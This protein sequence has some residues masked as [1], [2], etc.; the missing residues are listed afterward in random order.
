MTHIFKRIVVLINDVVEMESLLKKGVEFSK[1]HKTSLEVLFIHENHLFELPDY[2]LSP[3]AI[4]EKEINKE[5]IK[6]KIKSIIYSLEDKK[7]TPIFIVEEDSLDRVLYHGKDNK[8]ILFITS[9]HKELTQKL[10]EKTPYS[11]WILRSETTTYNN[12]LLPIDLSEDSSNIIKLTKHIFPKSSISIMH[13]YRYIL[14]EN[15]ALAPVESYLGQEEYDS[16]KEREK[17]IFESYKKE[18]NLQ[19]DFIQEKYKLDED[20]INYIT[21]KKSDLVVMH[22]QDADI[23]TSPSIIVHLLHTLPSDFLVFNF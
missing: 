8:D 7:E 20:L 15:A 6:E 21:E 10:L 3:T 16:D 2:F 22:H 14:S 13:E 11:Y 5:K 1:K 4:A 9:Y 18:F 23:F 12:I 17:E 19:G